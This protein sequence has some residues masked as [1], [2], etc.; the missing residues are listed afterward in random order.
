MGSA[1]QG[2]RRARGRAQVQSR[3]QFLADEPPLVLIL[4]FG[5]PRNGIKAV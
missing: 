5:S 3:E 1:R 4:F 2:D